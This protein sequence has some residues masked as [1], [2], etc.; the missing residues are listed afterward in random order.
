M[1][2]SVIIADYGETMLSANF[3]TGIGWQKRGAKH[4]LVVVVL[5]LLH[6]YSLWLHLALEGL[7]DS[8][9]RRVH[10]STTKGRARG[11]HPRRS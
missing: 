9:A 2:E 3:R 1:L 5:D 10:K 6:R 8:G 11:K 4:E 7:D